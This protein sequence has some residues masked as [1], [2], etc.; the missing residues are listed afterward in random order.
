MSETATE[1]TVGAVA[2]SERHTSRR[3]IPAPLAAL[4]LVSAILGVT[5]AVM[6]A[7][8]PTTSG[9]EIR[10]LSDQE[11]RAAMAEAATGTR[12]AALPSGT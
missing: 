1:T 8:P 5:W 4:L 3:R 7:N 9:G 10:Q 11:M 12:A 6:L 2:A